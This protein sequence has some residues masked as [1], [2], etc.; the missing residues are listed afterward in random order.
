MPISSET[1]E[2]SADELGLDPAKIEAVDEVE[3]LGEGFL[4][5]GNPRRGAPEKLDW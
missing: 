3:S 2:E 1:Y 4:P 5:N